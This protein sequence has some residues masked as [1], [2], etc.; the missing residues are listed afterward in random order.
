MMS[1]I[2]SERFSAEAALDGRPSNAYPYALHV[3]RWHTYMLTQRLPYGKTV[4]HPLALLAFSPW[5]SRGRFNMRNAHS[6]V[7][8]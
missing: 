5:P 7:L 3:W 4:T 2:Q 1:K 8:A 6:E